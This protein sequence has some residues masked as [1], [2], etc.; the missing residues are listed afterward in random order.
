M[1]RRT[2]WDKLDPMFAFMDGKE[3]TLHGVHGTFKHNAYNAIYPYAHVAE[4]LIH[5]ASAKGKRSATY[6]T[7]RDELGDDFV[8]D[9][10]D[11][12]DTLCEAAVK[13]G[14]TTPA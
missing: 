5:E 1:A 7:R 4:T 9:L 10:T 2:T 11:S 12:I 14:Y 6:Q 3:Y 13:L 8:T